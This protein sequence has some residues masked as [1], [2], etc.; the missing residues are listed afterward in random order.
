[1]GAVADRI[2]ADLKVAMKAQ[3]RQ[4]VGVLR[5]VRADLQNARIAAGHDLS[6][7]EEVAILSRAVKQRRESASQYRAVGEEDRGAAEEGEIA[8]IEPYLPQPLAEAEVVALIAEAIGELEAAERT[9]LGK[10]MRAV[11][12][13]VAGRADGKRVNE[14]VRQHLA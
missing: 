10:V 8:V 2:F 9:N 11:M 1:M 12:A 3:E 13:K 7:E 6:A 5:M 4:R 14:L